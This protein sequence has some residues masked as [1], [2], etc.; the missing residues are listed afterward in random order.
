MQLRAQVGWL[1]PLTVHE[2]TFYL[3]CL[4]SSVLMVIEP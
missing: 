2:H 3:N 1:L 4:L